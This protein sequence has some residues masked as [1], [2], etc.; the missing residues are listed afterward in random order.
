MSK[1]CTAQTQSDNGS[2]L[3]DVCTIDGSSAVSGVC[4]ADQLLMLQVAQEA[5]QWCFSIS[6]GTEVPTLLHLADAALA[7]YIGSLQV[8]F[9]D[10][11]GTQWPSMTK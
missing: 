5:Q 6:G 8:R 7:Q 3:P 11:S 10:L 1:T 2:A 9:T 4:M